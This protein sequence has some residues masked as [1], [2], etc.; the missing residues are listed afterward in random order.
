MK[1]VPRT[2]GRVVRSHWGVEDPA[3]AT[4]TESGID[5]AFMAA[6]RILGTLIQALLAL[7]LAALKGDAACLKAELDPDLH[8]SE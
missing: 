8:C 3:H 4:G 6:C 5:A 7:P 2:L 1:R